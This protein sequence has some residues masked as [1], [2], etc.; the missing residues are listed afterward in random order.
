[1][2]ITDPEVQLA[3]RENN[4]NR[5]IELIP[6]MD[7]DSEDM[8]GDT[9]PIICANQGW[10]KALDELIKSKANINFQNNGGQTALMIAI[11]KGNMEIIK[12]LISGGANIDLR[13]HVRDART[14]YDNQT[15]LGFAI[16]FS[17]TESALALIE[18]GARLD[19]LTKDND[20]FLIC[21]IKKGNLEIVKG[22]I[23]AGAEINFNLGDQI[24]LIIASKS[25]RLEIVKELIRAGA[26]VNLN[27]FDNNTALTHAICRS[28]RIPIDKNTRLEIVKE[29]IRAGANLDIQTGHLYLWGDICTPLGLAIFYNDTEIATLLIKEGANLDLPVSERGDTPLMKSSERGYLEITKELIGAG[30][31]VNAIN[32]EGETALFY[33]SQK[34]S[35]PMS[36]RMNNDRL[37]NIQE[38]INHGACLKIDKSQTILD[39]SDFMK[40][41]GMKEFIINTL[42]ERINKGYKDKGIEADDFEVLKSFASHHSEFEN[43]S[44]LKEA[45]KLFEES[46]IKQISEIL[47]KTKLEAH[48]SSIIEKS[49][50]PKKTYHIVREL[51]MKKSI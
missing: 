33:A 51:K 12:A 31:Y 44:K 29:L 27:T 45:F 1:M 43:N 3:L 19:L 30:A 36:W 38:L 11:T 35:P 6:Q 25:G 13:S 37:K 50:K 32:K 5:F 4:E 26:E 34:P 28:D 23:R 40:H 10:V 7:L 42:Y 2:K 20:T 18:A 9:M 41:P 21:A 14:I 17:K 49:H 22:L 8:I 47:A 16:T 24:P 48:K 15:P 39:C 46:S